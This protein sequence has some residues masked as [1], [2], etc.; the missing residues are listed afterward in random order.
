M[1]ILENVTTVLL[2][3]LSVALIMGVLFG[4]LLVT[5]YLGDSAPDWLVLV[6]LGWA[7]VLSGAVMT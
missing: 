5:L 3:I 1:K 7:F 4:P 2:A 6:S